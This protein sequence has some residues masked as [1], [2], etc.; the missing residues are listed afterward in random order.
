MRDKQI[1]D[2]KMTFRMAM[3]KDIEDESV[4]RELVTN[5]NDKKFKFSNKIKGKEI[6]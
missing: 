3:L 6:K 5:L 4:K 1:D 2:A